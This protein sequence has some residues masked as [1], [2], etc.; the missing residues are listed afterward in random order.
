MEVPLTPKTPMRSA[1]RPPGTPGR[2]IDPRSPTFKEEVKLEKEEEKTEKQN[3]ND[4]V[5]YAPCTNEDG[6]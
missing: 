1:L 4:L 2:F 3:A 5:R 6:Y